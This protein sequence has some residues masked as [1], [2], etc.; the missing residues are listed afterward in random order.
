MKFDY[1]K[2]DVEHFLESLEI[3]NLEAADDEEWRFSCPFPGHAHGDEMPSAYM[4]DRT[5]AWH[6]FS[7][8]KS[9]NAVSF[10]ADHEGVS[11]L[12][13]RRWLRDAYD[14]DWRE[15]TGGMTGWWHERFYGNPDVE[16]EVNPALDESVLDRFYVDWYVALQDVEGG[17]DDPVL[18]YMF[19]RGFTAETL[20]SW[21]IG[22]DERRERFT[23]PV[24][25]EEDSLI[26]FKARSW[27]PDN[28]PKYLAIG[29]RNWPIYGFRPYQKSQ[30]VF[31]MNEAGENDVL[32]IC[33]G[34]LNAIAMHQA[35]FTN[36]VAV[37]GSEVSER[38][39]NIIRWH[40]DEVILFFD[41]LKIDDDGNTVKDT[42]GQ[43]CTWGWS[44]GKGR[45]HPG[46]V[47]LLEPHMTVR[48]VDEHLG[49]PAEM[50][51]D[52]IAKLIESAQTSVSLRFRSQVQ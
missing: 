14:T 19:D 37:S 43:R 3:R 36:A 6:C 31:G 44:D 11:I 51:P 21:E 26:G 27:N 34:E 29:D 48:V 46:A 8:K 9:G 16:L 49:D 39:A 10:L 17:S 42:A 7:C 28:K 35:G 23:I 52:E 18:N 1:E 25:D 12:E 50:N 13:A 38:Q 4:N 40:A 15:P 2:I 30:V 33:E 22:Y 45:Y 32:I 41:S 47:D 5:T 24:R 20:T